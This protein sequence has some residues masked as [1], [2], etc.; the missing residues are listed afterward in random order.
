MSGTGMLKKMRS[1]RIL[2][3]LLGLLLAYGGFIYSPQAAT[4]IQLYSVNLGGVTGVANNTVLAFDRFLLVA[5][6]W[7]SAGVDDNGDLDLTKLDNKF[8]YVVDT[9]KPSSPVLSKELSAWDSKQGA[10]KTI[11]FPSKL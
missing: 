5:P 3:V 9:K 8:L 4:P 10:A 6:F 2:V 11:Y 7:P 1:A